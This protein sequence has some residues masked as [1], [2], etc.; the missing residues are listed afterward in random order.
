MN[1]E[2]NYKIV[3]ILFEL[4]SSSMSAYNYSHLDHFAS[5]KYIN[6]HDRKKLFYEFAQGLLSSEVLSSSHCENTIDLIFT[7]IMNSI[8]NI[9][10]SSF[11]I[12]IAII[13]PKIESSMALKVVKR[14]S[15][16]IV[17]NRVLALRLSD[18]GFIKDV[19]ITILNLVCS[20]NTIKVII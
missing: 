7:K 10:D 18:I 5:M 17:N 20:S 13:L 8:Q 12:I 1:T 16:C 15:Q 14:M 4:V 3:T 9:H 19:V 11:S 6:I 2:D